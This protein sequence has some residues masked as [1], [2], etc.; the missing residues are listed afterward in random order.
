MTRGG[1]RL[2]APDALVALG[3]TAAASLLGRAVSIAPNERRWLP[4]ADG[5]RVLVV[6]HPA[7]LL[8]LPDAL[9][10]AAVERWRDALGQTDPIVGAGGDDL[11]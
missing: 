5:R 3:A 4:R 10:E 11:R 1:D 6:R 8:R 9:R 2:G 7:A